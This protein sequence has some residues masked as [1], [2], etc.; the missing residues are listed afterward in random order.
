MCLDPSQP[1]IGLAGDSSAEAGMLLGD[2]GALGMTY[3]NVMV[4]RPEP[5]EGRVEP[6]R[7]GGTIR[8]RRARVY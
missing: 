4:S 3:L 7:R 2:L 6:R 1:D 5:V 8:G